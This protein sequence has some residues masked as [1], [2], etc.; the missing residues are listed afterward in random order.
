[1]PKTPKTQT[2]A[3]MRAGGVGPVAKERLKDY[4]NRAERKQLEENRKRL[5]EERKQKEL[6]SDSSANIV[7]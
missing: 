3:R 6:G 7:P 1:M 4:K 5:E 2:T